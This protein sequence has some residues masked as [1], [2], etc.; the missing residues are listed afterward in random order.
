MKLRLAFLFALAC[1]STAQ[2]LL[3][4]VPS[5]FSAAGCSTQ[6]DAGTDSTSGQAAI[7]N[8]SGEKYIALSFTATATYTCC[9]IDVPLTRVGAP[10]ADIRVAIYS[11]SS[12]YPST[13][14]STSNAVNASTISTTTTEVSFEGL[15]ASI[16]SGVTYWVVVYTATAEGYSDYIKWDYAYAGSAPSRSSGDGSSWGG[17]AS[18]TLAK[19]KSFSN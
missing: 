17:Y 15:S 16:S 2:A 8:W 12:A 11:D 19:F 10:V 1:A 7:G 14:L 5:R 3:W 9:R 4:I 18:S 6:R 13:L